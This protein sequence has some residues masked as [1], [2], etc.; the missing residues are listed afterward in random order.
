MLVLNPPLVTI[1]PMSNSEP[2]NLVQ[3]MKNKNT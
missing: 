2:P 3:R 1:V